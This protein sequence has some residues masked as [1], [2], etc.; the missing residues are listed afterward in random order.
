MRM[1]QIT[2]KQKKKS[3]K[4]NLYLCVLQPTNKPSIE[5]NYNYDMLDR[6]S[7]LNI[8]PII[9]IG[10]DFSH[11]HNKQTMD[12]K[13]CE[14]RQKYLDA[15]PINEWLLIMD[16]DETLFGDFNKLGDILDL[17]DKND[18]NFG[19]ICEYLPDGKVLGRPRLLKKREGLI[20]GGIPNKEGTMWKHDI[21]AYLKP[22]D[23]NKWWKPVNYIDVD[24][25][26][27]F[28]FIQ[29]FAFFHNKSGWAMDV[30]GAVKE[31]EKPSNL[32]ELIK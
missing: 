32:L 6:D 19:M 18:K 27:N 1:K 9:V 28:A 13:Q 30:F 23:N 14:L 11:R 8:I 20:Y 25:S 7:G 21:I 17:L 5:T 10:G 15:V 16:S 22:N 4:R 3:Q 12:R 24:D 26:D 2:K 29:L 31:D